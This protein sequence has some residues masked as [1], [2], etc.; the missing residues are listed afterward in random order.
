MKQRLE[1]KHQELQLSAV[2]V[3]YTKKL[4]FLKK[5]IIEKKEAETRLEAL[6]DEEKGKL[7]LIESLEQHANRMS[8]VLQSKKNFIPYETH[9]EQ[10]RL[11]YTEAPQTIDPTGDFPRDLTSR[12][13]YCRGIVVS[14]DGLRFQGDRL[15]T[16]LKNLAQLGF[17]CFS[18]HNEMEKRVERVEESYFQYKDEPLL[19]SW[20]RKERISPIVLC[21][22]VLQSAWFD[23]LGKKTIWYDI[24]D[25]EDVLWG[26][27]AKS[28]LK[29]Y[30]LVKSSEV[31]TYSDKKWKK[32]AAYRKDALL[33]I[34]DEADKNTMFLNQLEARKHVE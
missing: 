20:L 27:D 18:F 31:V 34:S 3:K 29:H 33:L 11:Y 10:R 19:L 8:Q 2:K 6:R 12:L 28:R 13:K 26:I 21:S 14:P 17:L 24:N 32:Y 7:H 9:Y 30:E 5:I 1:Q 22:W 25:H 15:E 23:L 4:D 16:L